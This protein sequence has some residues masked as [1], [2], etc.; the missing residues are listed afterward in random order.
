M[1]KIG[2][3]MDGIKIY[4]I[5]E[6]EKIIKLKRIEIIIITTPKEAV[7][8]IMKKLKKTSIKGILNFARIHLISDNK[9]QIRQ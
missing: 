2:W 3:E 7:E 6:L 9:I 8:E 4:D 1:D 5:D